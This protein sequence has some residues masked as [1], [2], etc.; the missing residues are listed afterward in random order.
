MIVV[1]VD[2]G[3]SRDF[4]A[5]AVCRRVSVGPT[6]WEVPHL[7]RLPLGTA[8]TEAVYHVVRLL[9]RPELQRA[10]LAVDRTGVGAAVCDLLAANLPKGHGIRLRPIGLTSGNAVSRRLARGMRA[11]DVT[12]STPPSA[13]SARASL[14]VP[15]VCATAR[16]RSARVRT[17]RPTI[18]T[19]DSA[20]TKPGA[21]DQRVG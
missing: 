8:Y 6:R 10:Y 4:T 7:E 15:E 17:T 21:D 1:G 11:N 3:Q 12:T 19:G 18:L 16:S 2:L 5:I 14:P 13:A 20:T 9:E